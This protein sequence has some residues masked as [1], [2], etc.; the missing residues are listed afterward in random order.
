MGSAETIYV[1]IFLNFFFIVA[2]FVC[3]VARD[4]YFI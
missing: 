1:L 3:A 4:H 2:A